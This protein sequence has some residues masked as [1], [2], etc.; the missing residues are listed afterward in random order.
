MKGMKA[1]LDYCTTNFSPYQNKTVRIVEFPRYATFAQSFP[2]SIPYSEAIGFIA[3]VDPKSEEDINYPYYVTAHEVAHQWWAHQ[4]IGGNVQGAT[5]MSESLAQYTAMMVM[6]HEVGPEQMR[7]FLKYEMDRYL[8]GR[9]VERKK[10]LPLERVENQGYI[11]YNKASVVFY[12]L[13]DYAGEENVN[14]A[15][16]DYVQAVAYQDPPYTN[17]VELIDAAAQ[18]RA[19]RSTPTSSTT[20]SNRSRC[21]K[22]ARFRPAIAPRRMENTR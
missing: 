19:R 16:H 7:R 10:E 2:A 1:A 8:I 11:H 21:T 17:A 3:R 20:C 5:L 9:S 13:Q 14:R 15:L 22:T 12:A 18:N 6:K 4:V